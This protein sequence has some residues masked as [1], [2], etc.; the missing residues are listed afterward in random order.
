[1]AEKDRLYEEVMSLVEDEI[2]KISK[3]EEL[4]EKCLDYL[5]KLVDIAKDIET[6]SAMQSE[7]G[8][9]Y[10]NRMYYDDGMMHGNSYRQKRDSMGRYSRTG[11]RGYSRDGDVMSRLEMMMNEATTEREREAIRRALDSM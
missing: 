8:G 5:Y 6:I 2:E 7:Y 1:M 10:S 3:K 9:G 11:Y 4:D